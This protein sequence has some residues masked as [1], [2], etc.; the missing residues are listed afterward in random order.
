MYYNTG[1]WLFEPSDL[2]LPF[3]FCKMAMQKPVLEIECDVC[4]QCEQSQLNLFENLQFCLA[5]RV[6]HKVHILPL[7]SVIAWDDVVTET[8]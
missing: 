5:S 3:I 8:F 2:N 1:Y 7:V 4:V 6:V